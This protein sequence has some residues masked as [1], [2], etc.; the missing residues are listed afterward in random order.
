[1]RGTQAG[2]IDSARRSRVNYSREVS[3]DTYNYFPIF[4]DNRSI[5]VMT[6]DNEIKALEKA[7]VL[8]WSDSDEEDSKYIFN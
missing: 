4:S 5:S 2:S 7:G 8:E 1:M 3:K 6:E